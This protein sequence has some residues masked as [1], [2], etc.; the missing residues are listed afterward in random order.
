[1]GYLSYIKEERF[2]IIQTK[3]FIKSVRSKR[4]SFNTDAIET[5]DYLLDIGYMNGDSLPVYE[6]EELDCKLEDHGDYYMVY[7]RPMHTEI[8]WEELGKL[9]KSSLLA[10]C[11][12]ATIRKFVK[13]DG[14]SYMR[15]IEGASRN[16][17]VK[18]WHPFSYQLVTLMKDE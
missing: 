8:E 15:L 5:A 17:L 1:M 3:S 11:L 9:S 7:V 4:D 14:G 2:P 10:D 12:S 6:N 13:I 16:K 18:E